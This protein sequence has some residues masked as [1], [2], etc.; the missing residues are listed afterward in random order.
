MTAAIVESPS[1][2]ETSFTQ[3]FLQQQ[4]TEESHTLSTKYTYA[5]L[6]ATSI[7]TTDSSQSEYVQTIL[8]VVEEDL[9]RYNRKK[10]PERAKYVL[11]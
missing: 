9:V 6:L 5:A 2:T 1:E 11:T 4:V 7:N 8:D 10:R 3:V